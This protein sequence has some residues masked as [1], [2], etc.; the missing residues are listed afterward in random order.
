MHYKILQGLQQLMA[1]QLMLKE[2]LLLTGF[3]YLV[4]VHKFD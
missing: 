1:Q 4:L 2:L 3:A